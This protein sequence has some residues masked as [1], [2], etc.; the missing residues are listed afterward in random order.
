MTFGGEGGGERVGGFSNKEL[1]W[2]SSHDTCTITVS[3]I[4][5]G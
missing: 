2:D 1:V 4:G 5:T 3:R